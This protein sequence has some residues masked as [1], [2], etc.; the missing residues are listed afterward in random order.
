MH[1]Y[2]EAIAAFKQG[3]SSNPSS[4]RL[5]IWLAATYAQS[6]NLEDASWE[7]EQVLTENPSLRLYMLERAFPFSNPDD[8]DYF[9]EGLRKAGLQQ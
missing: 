7:I 3:L 5:R 8:L 1:Q 2:E 6:S 9:L 4:E